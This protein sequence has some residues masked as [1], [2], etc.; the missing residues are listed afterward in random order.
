MNAIQT[1]RGAMPRFASRAFG[2]V[3]ALIGSTLSIA[4]LRF[5]TN[6]VVA[7]FVLPED[8]GVVHAVA[9]LALTLGF[10]SEAGI[11]PF[12]TR[13]EGADEPRTASVVW[14]VA[15]LRGVLMGGVLLIFA[16]PMARLLDNPVLTDPI[17]V[18]AIGVFLFECRSMGPYL[19]ARYGNDRKNSG[20]RLAV[21]TLHLPLL[22]GLALWL[23]NYWALVI[24]NVVHSAMGVAT[25]FLFY[26]EARHH[27]FVLDRAIVGR[28]WRFS[29]M[30]AASSALS[31]LIMQFERFFLIRT[32]TLEVWGLFAMAASLAAMAEDIGFRHARNILMPIVSA[33]LR[34]GRLGPDSYY[35]PLRY[36]RPGLVMLCCAGITAGPAFFDALFPE[37]YADAGI[38][39]S[40][41][42]GRAALAAIVLPTEAL[43]VADDG[44]REK[45]YCDL[46]R[47]VWLCGVAPLAYLNFGLVGF[48]LAVALREV[49]ALAVGYR[50]LV[51]RRLFSARQELP[52]V[53]AMVVGLAAGLAASV[54]ASLLGLTG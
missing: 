17:R 11:G 9:M 43:L 13:E 42:S 47:L 12:M 24:A 30:I 18:A 48:V 21:Y 8:F 35:R 6:L 45:V 51:R 1:M 19:A 46:S 3:G 29:R 20:I 23:Q 2:N 41:L 33:D 26:P 7:R 14:T 15:V 25:S 16:E 39:L 34:A 54:T 38:F 27:R 37:R 36:L 5:A 28:L 31:L 52:V 4:V 44:R 49:P 32:T 40:I 22:I 10:L 50:G 53:G